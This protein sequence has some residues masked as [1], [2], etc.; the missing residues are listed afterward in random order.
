MQRP[1]ASPIRR[2]G[3]AFRKAHL[4]GAA[5]LRE[6]LE[7]VTVERQVAG[8]DHN[9]AIV[10]VPCAIQRARLSVDSMECQ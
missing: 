5:V 7:A 9:R 1:L 4:L 6:E 8:R 3:I 2:R 10:L